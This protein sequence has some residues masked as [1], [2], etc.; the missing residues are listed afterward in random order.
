MNIARMSARSTKQ[1]GC[2]MQP[3]GTHSAISHAVS[4][5]KSVHAKMSSVVLDTCG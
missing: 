5:S 3:A 1:A 2:D 4:F